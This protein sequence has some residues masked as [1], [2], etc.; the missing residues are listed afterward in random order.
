MVGNI[1]I[2]IATRVGTDDA[3]DRLTNLQYPGKWSGT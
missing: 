3:W 2:V 1:S